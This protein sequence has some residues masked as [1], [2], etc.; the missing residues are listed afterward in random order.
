MVVCNLYPFLKTINQQG[1]SEEDALEN[2]DIGGVT[3]LRAAAKNYRNVI[4]LCEPEDYLTIMKS[5]KEKKQVSFEERKKFAMKAF[6][7]TANYDSTISS[8]FLNQVEG[9]EKLTSSIILQI[10]KIEDL[11]Y[12]ENPHQ[13][14]SLYRWKDSEYPFEQIQGKQLSYNNLLDMNAA[15]ETI[16]SFEE[17]ACAIIKHLTPCGIATSDDLVE[18]YKLALASDPISAFGSII[19]FNREVTLPLVEQIGQ[20]FLEVLVAK[21]YTPQALEWL[22]KKKKNCR[23]IKLIS[24]L[25]HPLV[26]RSV[27]GGLLIQTADNSK[28]IPSSWKIVTQKKPDEKM[29][30]DFVF[31]WAAVKNVKSNAIVFTQ[32]TS[33]VGIGCGQP[34]RLDS[35]HSAGTHSGDK[36]HGALCSSD[37]FFP[38]PDGVEAA[39]SYG[40]A[41]IIQPG[42]SIR[43]EDVISTA[44]RLGIVMIF[45]DERLFKH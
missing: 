5:M 34:N 44:D 12:G 7:H 20:L 35:V 41:G 19:S 1:S 24:Q 37:A 38:F 26:I 22:T 21:S 23:V 17:P 45:T 33:T 25:N 4:V 29:L 2:I 3:L 40:I 43:D 16:E 9:S 15:W 6:L 39:V 28:P 32:G 36:A 8:Y 10:E 30:K 11:R 18:S 14:A 27:N 13:K 31:A 42:G